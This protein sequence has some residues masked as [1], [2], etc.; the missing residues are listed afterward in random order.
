MPSFSYPTQVDIVKCCCFLHNWIRYTQAYEDDYDDVDDLAVAN[1]D[2]N[3][4][5]YANVR[6]ADD[7]PYNEL[8]IWRDGIA[9]QMW[10]DYKAE[11]TRRRNN[12]A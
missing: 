3:N 11:L 9:Q 4:D 7:S 1:N 12:L 5:L 10:D 6:D 8:K 2:D